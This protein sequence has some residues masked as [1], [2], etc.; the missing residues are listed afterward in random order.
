MASFLRP[1]N[2]FF[3]WHWY[4][5]RS[6]KQR[7][8][9][10]SHIC[11]T[12]RNSTCE[13]HYHAK[14]SLFVY[15]HQLMSAQNKVKTLYYLLCTGLQGNTNQYCCKEG[16]TRILAGLGR[17]LFISEH[18]E[19]KRIRYLYAL[20]VVQKLQITRNHTT[21][22]YLKYSGGVLL[23]FFS[24]CLLSPFLLRKTKCVFLLLGLLLGIQF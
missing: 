21:L 6:V 13:V 5:P 7:W 3:S 15:Q 22:C 2:N 14:A 4:F 8:N 12:T 1:E 18:T 20:Y 23:F 17:Y 19:Q 11:L 24:L 10:H 9:E 16:F